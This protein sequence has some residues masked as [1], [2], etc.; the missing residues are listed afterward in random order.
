MALVI[1]TS[2]LFSSIIYPGMLAA[3]GDMTME[4]R[5]KRHCASICCIRGG[6][7]SRRFGDKRSSAE[8]SAEMAN[9]EV[10]NEV[11]RGDV[12]LSSQE[13]MNWRK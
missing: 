9:N 3:M 1:I 2:L 7:V 4:L 13:I 10:A 5:W 8:V 12:E 6:G 11:E